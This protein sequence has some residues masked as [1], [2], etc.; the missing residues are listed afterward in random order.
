[1]VHVAGGGRVYAFVYGV[2]FLA[3]KEPGVDWELRSNRFGDRYPLH[4]AVDPGTPN[5]LHVVADTGAIVTSRDDG[6]NWVSYSNHE[7]ETSEVI[8]RARRH[9][10]Y[11]CKSCHG[12]NGVGERP[13]DMYAQDEYGFVAP[14]LDDSAHGWHHSDGNLAETILKGSPR[15]PR[16]M[17]FGDLLTDEDARNIV[18]YIRS[19]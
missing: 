2:G 1:M 15:N 4:L 18:A 8:A 16:M 9:Y 3:G 10:E 5:L 17:P 13:D 7:R 6:R 14:P 19:L 12:D 11:F